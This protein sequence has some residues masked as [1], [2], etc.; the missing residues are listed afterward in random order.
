MEIP[1]GLVPHRLVAIGTSL[2]L[3]LLGLQVWLLS[4]IQDQSRQLASLRLEIAALESRSLVPS[5]AMQKVESGLAT[6]REELAP[7]RGLREEVRRALGQ[8]VVTEAPPEVPIAVDAAIKRWMPDTPVAIPQDSDELR[9]D[10]AALGQSMPIG[11]DMAFASRLRL[12]AWWADVVDVVHASVLPERVEISFDRAKALR[13]AAPSTAP[14]WCFE[15]ARGAER[16]YRDLAL[17]ERT[18]PAR[19]QDLERLD[20]AIALLGGLWTPGDEPDWA[21][22]RRKDLRARRGELVDAEVA[23]VVGEL[24]RT[25]AEVVASA[26]RPRLQLQILGGLDGNLIGLL[27]SMTEVTEAR[28]TEIEGLLAEW[29]AETGRLG[30]AISQDEQ[31]AYQRWALKQMTDID[32]ANEQRCVGKLGLDESE[33]CQV[34][35]MID[36]LVPI[37]TGLLLPPVLE[38]FNRVWEKWKTEISDLVGDVATG[39]WSNESRLKKLMDK[40]AETRKKGLGEV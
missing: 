20:E 9:E 32:E 21:E 17:E 26:R 34:D 2:A 37:D 16:R 19:I 39:S 10:I 40:I 31:L 35:L 15:A 3:V 36:Y 4:V 7:M 23:Q 1:T 24:R 33:D 5:G 11:T 22:Q 25:R 13:L 29:Q 8:V 38:E 6:V 28:R 30:H 18:A 14:D 27:S 12:L